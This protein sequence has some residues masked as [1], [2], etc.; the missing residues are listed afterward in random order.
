MT[1]WCSIDQAQPMGTQM[2]YRPFPC[3]SPYFIQVSRQIRVLSTACSTA[4]TPGAS[5]QQ[6]Q[7]ADAQL[8]KIIELKSNKFPKPPFFVWAK[9][10][11]HRVFWHCWDSLHIINGLLV[12]T[13]LVEKGPIPEYS[14]VIPT[15]LIDSVLQ[16]I[17][18]TPFSGHLG[19]KRTLLRKK[20]RFFWPKMAVQIKDFVRN[21]PVCAQTKLNLTTY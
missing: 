16:G 9:D 17:H 10:P 5:L 18:S 8:S 3:N 7:L 6:S 15:S 19:M 14:F 21:Y 20:N 4:I 2:P 11:I 12:K 1:L 13:S